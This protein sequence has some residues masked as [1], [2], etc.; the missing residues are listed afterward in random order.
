V[1]R[2]LHHGSASSW[3]VLSVQAKNCAIQLDTDIVACVDDLRSISNVFL[4]NTKPQTN[5]LLS[6]RSGLGVGAVTRP[7][8]DA[9]SVG[10]C[11]G[12]L[13]ALTALRQGLH[14]SEGELGGDGE[15]DG[16]LDEHGG[17]VCV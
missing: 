13:K 14:G 16:S 7:E 6:G 3:G 9:G 2:N 10:G 5:P 17:G 8:D 4:V 11:T 15:E 1:T 12:G